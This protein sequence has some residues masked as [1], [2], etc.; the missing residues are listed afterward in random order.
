MWGD[1]VI[2]GELI[3]AGENHHIELD[4][5]ELPSGTRIDINVHIFRAKKPG[6]SVLLLG[7]LH[8]DEIN[9]VEIVRRSVAHPSIKR[10]QCGQIIAIPLLNVFGFINFSR[11]VRDGKDVNRSFP[12]SKNGSLAG[13]VAYLMTNDILPHI[14]F[15]VDFHTGGSSI[16]N[17]PHLRVTHGDEEALKLA[18]IFAPPI[19][20]RNKAIAKSHRREAQ[21]MGKSVLVF[22]GGESL[23]LDENSIREGISG[24]LRLLAAHE[25]VKDNEEPNLARIF[26]ESKWVRAS[27]GGI[28]NLLV[29]AGDRVDKGQALAEIHNLDRMKKSMVKSPLNGYVLSNN[30]NPVVSRGDALIHLVALDSETD[31]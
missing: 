7:G 8:G 3:R 31:G 30:N 21:K 10:L 2:G 24:I 4:V 28:V 15:G 20:L 29:H 11:S 26:D 12:G 17:Y 16:F 27:K 1:V 13:R 25:M 18:K 14:D 9:G 22:E 5:A 19:I 6:P 23:R